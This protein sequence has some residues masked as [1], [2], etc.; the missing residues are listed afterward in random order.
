MPAVSTDAAEVLERIED[1]F[2]ALDEEWRITYLNAHASEIL[3]VDRDE[4]V[5]AVVWDAFEDAVGT[6][7]QRKYEEAMATQDPVSFEEYYPPLETWFEVNAYPSETA[8]SVYFRDVTDRIEREEE[9]VRTRDLLE[10]AKQLADVGGWELDAETME[11]FWSDHLFEI[12][13]ID[14]EEEPSLDEMLDVYHEADRDA[15]EEAVR[16]ALDSGDPFDIEVRAVSDDGEIQ[17]IHAKGVPVIDDGTVTKV[18][19]TAQDITERKEREQRLRDKNERLTAF[20][21]LNS[22]IR[23]LMEAIFDL[24]SR[25]EIEE[26]VCERLAFSDSYEFAWIGTAT[27]GQVR[28]ST[29]AGGDGYLDDTEI[30]LDAGPTTGGPTAQA[31][32]TGEL[33]VI[34]DVS[35]YEGYEPWR[36]HAQRFGYSAFAAIPIADGGDLHGTLNVY[37]SRTNAFSHEEREAMRHFGSIITYALESVEQGQKIQQERNRLEFINRLLRHNLLNSLNVVE[38][39]LDML[40]G[41]VDYEVLSELETA[42]D[43]TRE[44]IDFVK[45]IQQAADVIGRGKHQELR[46]RDIGSVLEARV[47][48]AQQAYPEATYH[49]GSAPSVDVVADSLLEEV[50]DNVLFNAVQHNPDD[51]PT[52]WVDTTV[53]AESVTVSIADDGPG[54]P[55]DR[56]STL[57]DQTTTEFD[58]P[59]SGFGLYLVEE[60]VDSYG[61]TIRVEENE[62]D[63]TVFRMR[64]ERA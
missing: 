49:F 43:R 60:I 57:F 4:A 54:I 11:A 59:D 2:F 22:L 25:S 52:V 50:L 24:S 9:L 34:R 17:W 63:G 30:R 5:G 36:E 16:G 31:H 14:G 18:R 19:G 28:V 45:T 42:S 10:Q 46:P 39:R 53:D 21:D 56:A 51:D 32:L 6:T 64:F 12:L 37:S 1:A 26:L 41:R 8:L 58:D 29:G 48:S 44:M 35:T 13:G 62:P 20:S 55:D 3:E 27:D 33:Q 38:A 15:V 23:D 61:G 40:D 47:T 7:F